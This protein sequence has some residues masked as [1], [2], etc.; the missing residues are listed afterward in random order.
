MENIGF[1]SL[2]KYAKRCVKDGKAARSA[3]PVDRDFRKGLS[4]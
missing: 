3:G 1:V 4:M 2:Q